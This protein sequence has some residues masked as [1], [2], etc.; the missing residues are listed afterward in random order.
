[1]NKILS[2][3]GDHPVY[4]ALYSSLKEIGYSI[5]L[6]NNLF[7]L[8][9]PST[10]ISLNLI[11]ESSL[12]LSP[13][14]LINPSIILPLIKKKTIIFAEEWWNKNRLKDKYIL[15][16]LNYVYSKPN[17]IPLVFT[18]KSLNS[19]KALN[20]IYLPPARKINIYN[21]AR[22]YIITIARAHPGKNLELVLDIAKKAKNENFIIIT[23]DQDKQYFLK[24]LK[25]AKELNNVKIY[26]NL[27][28]DEK[29]RLLREAKL[30]L[31]PSIMGPIEYVVVEAISYG[32]P[33]IVY[34]N[35]GLAE[36]LNER[37][38]VKSKD[39]EE[40]INKIRDIKEED[41]EI[42]KE[43]ANKFDIEGE[44]YKK[45]IEKLKARIFACINQQL[46]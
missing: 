19:L 16:F 42:A 25:R 28:W 12:Y 24:I 4:N 31:H 41:Y 45:G 23:R 29:E 11:K 27:S 17:S 9:L 33:S 46:C 30:L 35:I 6:E 5:E 20:P 21:G 32:I 7:T 22:D 43:L 39:I 13:S 37:W 3:I 26:T 38:V 34:K 8:Q 44:E 40:W 10:H 2:F 18:T 15:S 14:P 1:M 36:D